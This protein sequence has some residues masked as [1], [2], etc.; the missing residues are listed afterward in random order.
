M[1]D[2]TTSNSISVKALFFL[3]IVD[4]L[5]GATISTGVCHVPF[6]SITEK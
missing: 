4:L 2:T 3:V 5:V 6:L 1:M